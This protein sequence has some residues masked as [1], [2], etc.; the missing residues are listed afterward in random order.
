[1][2]RVDLI[3]KSYICISLIFQCRLCNLIDIATHVGDEVGQLQIGIAHHD[4][5]RK[6]QAIE[7]PL[8]LFDNHLL[9][10]IVSQ[11]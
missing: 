9:L 8:V 7:E 11:V 5:D 2:F 4:L 6:V 10:I 1:M 3:E